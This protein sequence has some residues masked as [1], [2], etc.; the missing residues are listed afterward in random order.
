MLHKNERLQNLGDVREASEEQVH[1][2][3]DLSPL[4][5]FEGRIGI[6]FILYILYF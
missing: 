3:V 6:H 5:F 1:L 4:N 2:L